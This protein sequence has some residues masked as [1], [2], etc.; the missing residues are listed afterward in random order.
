MIN[1]QLREEVQKKY[2]NQK[3][4]CLSVLDPVLQ[5]LANYFGVSIR[6]PPGR[7]HALNVEYYHR[8]EAM[9]YIISHDDKQSA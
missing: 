2:K 5:G 6:G 7:Q 3:I 4:P 1:D 9:N 8:I